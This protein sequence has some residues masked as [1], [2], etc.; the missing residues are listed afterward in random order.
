MKGGQISPRVNM[1]QLEVWKEA[2][3]NVKGEF[4]AYEVTAEKLN[5]PELS[6]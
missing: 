4:I 3:G 6:E 1:I 2:L 5:H